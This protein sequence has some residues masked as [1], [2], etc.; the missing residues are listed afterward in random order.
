MKLIEAEIENIVVEQLT[1]AIS[2]IAGVQV[3]GTWQTTDDTTLKGNE[4]RPKAVLAVKAFPRAYETPT[5][6]DASI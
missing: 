1:S 4:E 5:I 3:I 6:P 2:S